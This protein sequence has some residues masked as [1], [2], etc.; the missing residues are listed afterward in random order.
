MAGGPPSTSG[1]PFPQPS[2]F[3]FLHRNGGASR[4]QLNL[5]T[6]ASAVRLSHSLS[7]HLR[8]ESV[9]RSSLSRITQ[10]GHEPVLREIWRDGGLILRRINFF[11]SSRS[12]AAA[13][14][15]TCLSFFGGDGSGRSVGDEGMAYSESS[16]RNTSLY[17]RRW[18]N[19]LIAVNVLVF[20]A[21]LATKGKLMLWGAKINSLID[22]GQLWRLVT[23]S[24]LHANI[25]HLMINCYSMNS[26]GPT[27]ESLCGSKRF[28]SLYFASALASSATSYWFCKSPAVGAS[29]AI[30]GLVGSVAM[31][32]I[33]HRGTMK[34]GKEELRHIANVIFLNMGIGLLSK[35]IDNWGH[36]GGLVGGFVF[37]WLVGPAW[38]FE[39]LAMDGRR[40]YV[41]KAPIRLLL[42]SK[43]G[44]V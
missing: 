32:V 13:A 27:V 9:L 7:R 38:K 42:N 5:V 1:L 3:G 25:G 40:V 19:V 15:T 10:I 16:T 24:F 33:R 35:G 37:S 30:F 29:G 18:T 44:L 2:G 14:Y 21:Q 36:L 6:T 8:L 11:G 43:K 39:Y 23:S 12:C 17:R 26:V 31:F 20:V 4:N 34:G 41:D 28:L 22:K